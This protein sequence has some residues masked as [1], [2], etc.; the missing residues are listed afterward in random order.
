VCRMVLEYEQALRRSLPLRA[1]A[2]AGRV[3]AGVK[4]DVLAFITQHGK[5]EVVFDPRRESRADRTRRTSR[6][7]G[8]GAGTAPASSGHS[9][10]SRRRER[11]QLWSGK[12]GRLHESGRVGR[13]G[14]P[15]NLCAAIGDATVGVVPEHAGTGLEG[16]DRLVGE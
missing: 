13:P 14:G 8:E 11:S 16:V 10:G 9:P 4:A 1:R 7:D 2:E 3:L 12:V 6:L 5:S 15:A